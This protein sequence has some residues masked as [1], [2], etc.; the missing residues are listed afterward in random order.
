MFRSI[1]F[2][3]SCFLFGLIDSVSV[4]S[5]FAFYL[6]SAKIRLRCFQCAV[7]NGGLF[8]MSVCLAEYVLRPLIDMLLDGHSPS[9][10]LFINLFYLAYVYPVMLISF[11]LNSI[12]YQE[13]ADEANKLIQANKQSNNQL[14]PMIKPNQQ[15]TSVNQSNS[16]NT[17]FDRWAGELY[18]LLLFGVV[19]IWT[20]LL[21]LLPIVGWPLSLLH[22]SWL[23]SLY[24][25]DY[26]WSHHAVPVEV[27]LTEFEQRWAYFTGFGLAAGLA[28]IMLSPAMS[29][30][31][32]AL[33][34]PFM[35]LIAAAAQPKPKSIQQTNVAW[36]RV[37]IF[38]IPKY[39]N[40]AIL[41]AIQLKGT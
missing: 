6:S 39:L 3:V 26:N 17:V 2:H 38:T 29:T 40:Y 7:L 15:T 41:K 33:L 22:W 1:Q 30:P 35:I 23:Y 37:P 21:S 5:M 13:I 9:I 16:P 4:A 14:L 10:N 8:L 28:T 12:W 19:S 25:F 11:A 27:R 32:L 24:S 18:R 31:I 20:Q 36:K 34:F